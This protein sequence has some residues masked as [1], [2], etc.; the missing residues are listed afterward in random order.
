MRHLTLNIP[1]TELQLSSTIP[2]LSPGLLHLQSASSYLMVYSSIAWVKI[3]CHPLFLSYSHTS[4]PVFLRHCRKPEE[5]SILY[6]CK[7]EARK[8]VQAVQSMK[9]YVPKDFCTEFLLVQRSLFF[10]T[11]E[12]LAT[13]VS[14]NQ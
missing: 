8:Q 4:N 3:L 13:L 5:L 7:F 6:F 11:R 9:K 1:K 10:G 2:H 12:P 14:I